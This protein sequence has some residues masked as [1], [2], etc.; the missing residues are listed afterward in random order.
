MTRSNQGPVIDP[1]KNVMDFVALNVKRLD[2]MRES[3]ERHFNELMRMTAETNEKIRQAESD[4]LNAIRTVDVDAVNR[5]AEVAA[6][7]ATA[8][9]AQVQASAEAMRAQVAATATAA[10][11][12]LAASVAQSAISQAAEIEPLKKDIADLRRAQYE[13]QGIK[14]QTGETRLNIGAILGGISVILVLIFGMVS[15]YFAATK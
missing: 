15:I 7:A 10:A 11:V 1:T 6:T 2:E 13:A 14:T 3:S 4:R 5:A 12:A 9:A 8:L